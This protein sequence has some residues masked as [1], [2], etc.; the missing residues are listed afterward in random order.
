MEARYSNKF[1]KSPTGSCTAKKF[2]FIE[3]T[4]EEEPA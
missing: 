1:F 3:G 4:L 2:Q